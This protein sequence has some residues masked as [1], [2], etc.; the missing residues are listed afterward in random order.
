LRLQRDK[1]GLPLIKEFGGKR[2]SWFNQNGICIPDDY[3]LQLGLYLYLRNATKGLFA[4]AFLKPED[5]AKPEDFKIDDH[6]IA[7]IKMDVKNKSKLLQYIE[8]AQAWYN[9]HIKT[10]HSP[11]MT[12]DDKSWLQ[13]ERAFLS[14]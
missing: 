1:N 5:Y 10:G 3:K 11:Q 13:N 4:I 2:A 14:R 6:E 12:E 9:R 8:T 7:L